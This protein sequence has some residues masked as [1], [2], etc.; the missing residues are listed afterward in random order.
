MKKIFFICLLLS[1]LLSSCNGKERGAV[2]MSEDQIQ[3]E[4]NQAV[5][6]G[7]SVGFEPTKAPQLQSGIPVENTAEGEGS[8]EHD[9]AE[10][11]KNGTSPV[12]PNPENN[13][14]GE[15]TTENSKYIGPEIPGVTA[16]MQ[17]AAFWISRFAS[18]DA[19]I[20]SDKEI[21]SYNTGNFER[22]SFLSDPLDQPQTISGDE[23]RQWIQG[24]SMPSSSTRYDANQKEYKASDYD[25]M[26]QNL[27]LEAIPASITVL[28]GLTVHRSLMRT[29]PSSRS[30]FSKPTEQ[31]NDYFVE[32]AV[33]P[34]E[35]V[36]IY[37]A[38]RDGKW[39]FAG[40]YHYKAWIPAEDVA[41]C[42][43]DDLAELQANQNKLVIRGAKLFT[44]A[45][46]DPRLSLLQLDMGVSLQLI[47][48]TQQE[49]TVQYPVKDE[50]GNLEYASVKLARTSEAA[51]GYLDYTTAGVLAQAF[52][53]IGE[54]YGWGGMNNARDC[55]SFLVDI[56]RSFGIRLPRNS[57][58]Q[59][60]IAGSI[61][62]QGKDRSER[63]RIIEGLRP[64]S[65][66][67]MPGHAMMYLGAFEGKHY[68]I[69][70]VASV[71][72]KGQGGELNQ[73]VLYQVAVTPLEVFN[74]KGTEYIMLLSTVTEIE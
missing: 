42:T 71:Y 56:Y 37:H 4:N 46:S 62:L 2:I 26:K 7:V 67:Y 18:A 50:A 5:D 29:W 20:L 14:S 53:F 68:I 28:Y 15:Q 72:E 33:Y 61:S 16:Q 64:G 38:S 60:Q 3:N 30:S 74:S 58:Q 21:S 51:K 73:I 6:S 57:D 41:L 1:V 22:L 13:V 19:I 11:D 70:D 66:L 55:T 35:P 45:T 49:Y 40:I 8:I 69:H 24:L 36:S 44:P 34:A 47:S 48:E 17:K 63:L 54:P 12:F 39:L 59:E 23:V 52:R 9:G 31:R 25:T 43:R 10:A 65:T 32:T 27:N